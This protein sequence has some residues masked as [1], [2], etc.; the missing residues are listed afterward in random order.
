MSIAVGIS[1]CRSCFHS[2]YMPMAF[3]QTQKQ[4][5]GKA[6]KMGD[7]GCQRAKRKKKQEPYD[8][9]ENI[10][11]RN[12]GKTRDIQRSDKRLSEWQKEKQSDG[13]APPLF[14]FCLVITRMIND[15]HQ[16]IS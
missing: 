10:S 5:N 9:Q 4:C 3:S 13:A 1:A 2:N 15:R 6:E 8:V 7:R 16:E 11:R 14:I 12:E